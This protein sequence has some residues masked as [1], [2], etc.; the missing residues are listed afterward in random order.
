M[1]SFLVGFADVEDRV[2]V[3]AESAERALIITLNAMH[4]PYEII[5]RFILSDDEA[6]F[7][8]RNGWR[9]VANRNN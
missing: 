7:M 1:N 5:E 4:H 9:I 3:T 2:Q 8:V 6:I